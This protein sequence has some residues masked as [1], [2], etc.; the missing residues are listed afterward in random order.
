MLR[1]LMPLAVL[2]LFFGLITTPTV[3]AQDGTPA[4]TPGITAPAT[5]T[6]LDTTTEVLPT[7]H[8]IIAVDRWRLQPSATAL[9]LPPLGGMVILTVTSG[10]LS[11]TTDGTEHPLAVGDTVTAG[12]EEVAFRVVG[13]DEATMFVVYAV[14]GFTDTAGFWG[15][16]P[17]AHR[18]D[19]LISTSTDALPGGAARVVLER[20]TAPPGSALPPQD[21][22]PLVWTEI[23]EGAVGMTLEGEELPF[24]WKSGAE[25]IFR[26]GQYLP[27][28]QPGTRMTL[29]NAED[30][31]LVLYRLTLMPTAA[32]APMTGTAS[33]S[34]P[35]P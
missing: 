33:A 6:L 7:G 4:A 5:E 24:R 34:T 16:D 11:A 29:R 17:I 8:V 35:A 14:A 15:T 1:Y 27:V 23:G 21:V 3:H 25:R 18:V 13:S 9:T 30:A 12:D 26:H 19:F 10:E 20:V 28:L 22:T 31:P 2:A 32:E